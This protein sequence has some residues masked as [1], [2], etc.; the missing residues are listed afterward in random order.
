MLFAG[1]SE[2]KLVFTN[3]SLLQ[4]PELSELVYPFR[5]PPGLR[6]VR[7]WPLS[8]LSTVLLGRVTTTTKWV[9]SYLVHAISH[10]PNLPHYLPVTVHCPL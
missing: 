3:I 7:Y 8:G 10:H 2:Q 9:P 4:P 6:D 5:I 1:I